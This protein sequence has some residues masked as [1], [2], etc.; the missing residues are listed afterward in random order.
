M[1]AEQPAD[2]VGLDLRPRPEHDREVRHRCR[3][4]RWPRTP[5]ARGGRRAARRPGRAPWSCRLLIGVADERLDV[6]QD[7]VE[8][9]GGADAGCSWSRRL[10]RS[11]PN[12]SASSFIASVMPSVNSTARS[13]APMG[14][15]RS[16]MS[17][18]K[19]PSR[20]RRPSTSPSGASIWAPAGSPGL[21]V[22]E[23]RV[24]RP[25]VRDAPRVEIDD[26][27]RHRDE[28]LLVEARRENAI[29]LHQQPAGRFVD[30]AQAQ[31]EAL[32]SAM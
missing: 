11:S 20:P 6:L 28:A 13:P 19:C 27:V 10:S 23:R 3:L 29:D 21:Q 24:P 26:G 15:V 22:D 8:Q 25:G 12:M 16:S 32:S 5:G 7:A 9:C 14:W 4:R 17:A 18:S 2:D 1:R 30:G 31:D